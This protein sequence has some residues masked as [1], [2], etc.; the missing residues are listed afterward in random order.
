M[1]C[2]HPVL[3][4]AGTY[5]FLFG[6]SLWDWKCGDGTLA[7]PQLG[8]YVGM[9]EPRRKVKTC[10]TVELHEDGTYRMEHYAPSRCKALAMACLTMYGY[11]DE[12]KI[13]MKKEQ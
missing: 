13:N 10:S 8:G 5:D 4:Y 2:H 7:G 12:N 11:F 6:T 9:I 1:A 3:R